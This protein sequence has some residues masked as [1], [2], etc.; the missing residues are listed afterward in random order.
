MSEKERGGAGLAQLIGS[1][2][3]VAL[4]G[5]PVEAVGKPITLEV[6]EDAAVAGVSGVNRFM[7]RLETADLAEGR[8]AFA[9]AAGTRMAGPP[10]AMALEQAFLERLSAVATFSVDD[11]VLRLWAGDN[12]ALTFERAGAALP[13]PGGGDD[14][15]AP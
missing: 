5:K 11:D 6:A 9:P 7:T 1:W 10:E 12:E 15:T 8:L 14:P 3:L 13:G 4:D 2:S